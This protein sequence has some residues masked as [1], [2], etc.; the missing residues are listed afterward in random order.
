G[1]VLANSSREDN[2]VRAVQQQQVGAEVM[3]YRGHKN[4]KSLLRY[5]SALLGILF[6]VAQ[7]IEAAQSE[8]SGSIRQIIQQLFQSFSGG[9]HQR[10]QSKG[11]EIADAV[12]VGQAGLR[13][14]AQTRRH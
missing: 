1:R 12:V 14:H 8:Q 4:I 3:P 6:K 11:I 7:I 2:G 13:A 9:A 5:G 10:R